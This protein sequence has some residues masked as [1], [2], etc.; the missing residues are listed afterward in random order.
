MRHRLHL[1]LP[2]I[3]LGFAALAEAS[4]ERLTLRQMI[5]KSDAGL[6]GEIIATKVI[7]VPLDD[8]GDELTF[9]EL[10]IE[11]ADL[12][13]GDAV[14]VTVSY[15]G[16]V[17]P[18]DRGSYNSEAPSQDDV[19]LGNRVLAFYTWTDN[20]GGGHATNELHA[21]HGGLFRT[22][23]DKQ[24]RVVVQGRGPGYAVSRNM[25]LADLGDLARAHRK[26]LDAEAERTTGK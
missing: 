25:R 13:T 23:T 3:V 22:F 20:L 24:G 6:V 2:I 12:I 8:G 26:S 18:G 21:W 1:L 7:A 4:I 16:G 14:T 15:P 9:T 5:A 19:K 10:T 17:L 11:G